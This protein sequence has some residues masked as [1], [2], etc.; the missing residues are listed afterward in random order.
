MTLTAPEAVA[1]LTGFAVDQ[2]VIT[3]DNPTTPPDEAAIL[4]QLRGVGREDPIRCQYTS[5]TTPTGSTLVTALNKANLSSAYASNATTGTLIQRI[6]H[7]LVV[8]NEAP[9]VCGRSLAGTLTG[10]V[11]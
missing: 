6:F 2:V 3:R 10:S 7:R 5:A 8:M 9:T 4:I 1:T 11:P